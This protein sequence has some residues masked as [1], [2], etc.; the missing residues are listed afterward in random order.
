M[1]RIENLPFEVALSAAKHG[2]IIH[3]FCKDDYKVSI[4][5]GR[6]YSLY[7]E[8]FYETF[9]I[10]YESL[11]AEDWIVEYPDDMV[12]QEI[13]IPSVFSNEPGEV[14]V[15]AVSDSCTDWHGLSDREA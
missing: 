13:N 4:K 8:A 7:W 3:R 12:I 14:G 6:F 11:L 10:D 5:N 1:K 2:A 9:G 15:M